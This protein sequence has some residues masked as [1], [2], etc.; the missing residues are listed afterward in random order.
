[1]FSRLAEDSI[2]RW[3]YLADKATA[4]KWASSR[5]GVEII[6]ETEKDGQL[7]MYSRAWFFSTSLAFEYSTPARRWLPDGWYM[8][9]LHSGDRTRW[10]EVP[11]EVPVTTRVQLDLP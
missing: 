6:V 2:T 8:F 4:V 9:G 5:P 10:L 3:T 1:L 11:F 7:V